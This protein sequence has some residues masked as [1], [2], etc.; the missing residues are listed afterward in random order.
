MNLNRTIQIT[1]FLFRVVIGFLFFEHG[2]MKL[3]GWFGGIGGQPGATV[4]LISQMGLAGI[5]ECFGGIMIMLGLFTRP[6]AFILSGEMAVAYWQAHAPHGIWPIMNRGEL[7]AL[8]CFIFLFM[9]A[10]GG[11]DVSLDG[12]IRRRRKGARKTGQN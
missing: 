5:L 2:A 11:G 12:L 10:F 8:Y 6:V 7:A 4:E 9:A 3:F 1:F